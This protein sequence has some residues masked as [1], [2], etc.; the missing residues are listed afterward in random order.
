MFLWR[1]EEKSCVGGWY[2]LFAPACLG[3]LAANYGFVQVV[4]GWMPVR[5]PAWA[6][7]PVTTLSPSLNTGVSTASLLRGCRIW[8]KRNV[9]LDTQDTDWQTLGLVVW[10]EMRLHS[11]SWASNQKDMNDSLCSVQDYFARL[12]NIP[13]HY[14]PSDTRGDTDRK[15]FCAI[16]LKQQR[17]GE[18][19]RA[20]S[21]TP[22]LELPCGHE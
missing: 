19:E 8:W 3:C 7:G 2:L 6:S 14:A 9:Q 10:E 13:F 15:K 20:V 1:G 5:P 12:A 22:G 21:G 16:C 4:D 17:D 11:K 18:R